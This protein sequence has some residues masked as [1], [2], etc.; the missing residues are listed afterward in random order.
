MLVLN[1]KIVKRFILT[2]FG[3]VSIS[4]CSGLLISYKTGANHFIRSINDGGWCMKKMVF[5][6]VV[7]FFFFLGIFIYSQT[8]E[9]MSVIVKKTQAREK[10]SY[11]GKVLVEF[12]Y[13]DKVKTKELQ[14]NWYKIELP[15]KDEIGWVHSSALT[16][17]QVIMK[18]GDNEVKKYA[19]S[20]DVVLAG[21]GFNDRVEENY[22][23][24]SQ[25]DFSLVDE[26][27]QY[28]VPIDELDRFLIDG[29]FS[30]ME[31]RE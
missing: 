14:K 9:Y 2:I 29:G 17:K 31:G 27:E 15:D 3:I 13:G 12:Q 7:L 24:D 28:N 30:G 20:E 18:A 10:P 4:H 11:L 16:K 23:N 5:I 19:S 6:I 8:N 22:K 26:M 25:L 21:K 1:S